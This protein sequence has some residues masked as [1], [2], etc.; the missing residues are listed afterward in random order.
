MR[1]E[2]RLWVQICSFGA[3]GLEQDQVG[4]LSDVEKCCLLFRTADRGE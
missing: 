4:A 1:R 3:G 2:A